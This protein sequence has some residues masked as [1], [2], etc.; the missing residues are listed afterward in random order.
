MRN[1]AC[2]GTQTLKVPTRVV[3]LFIS[4]SVIKVS[5]IALLSR[6]NIEVEDTN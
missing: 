6:C 5:D 4:Y 3:L 2:I 1:A